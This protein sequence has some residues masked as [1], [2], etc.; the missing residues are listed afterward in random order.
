MMRV[1]I[2]EDHQQN[3]LLMSEVCIAAGLDHHAVSNGQAAIAAAGTG[4]F[5]LAL[6]DVHMP[7]ASGIDVT[8]AIR[9]LLPP[10][11]WMPVIAITADIDPD[12][13]RRCLEAGV[14]EI[15]LKPID[16]EGLIGRMHR[17]RDDPRC[18][19]ITRAA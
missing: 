13:H 5:A 17:W 6:L 12:M 11:A 14:D 2:G 19:A 16:V 9:S 15:I 18:T 7:G 3:R 4:D 10:L 1:L 8:R